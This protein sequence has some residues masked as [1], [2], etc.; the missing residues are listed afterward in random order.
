MPFQIAFSFTFCPLLLLAHTNQRYYWFKRTQPFWIQPNVAVGNATTT[1]PAATASITSSD[2]V[3]AEPT[4]TS[5]DALPSP[6]AD[7]EVELRRPDDNDAAKTV[8]GGGIVGHGGEFTFD[9]IPFPTMV[10]QHYHETLSYLRITGSQAKTLAQAQSLVN[11][12]EARYISRV[13]INNNEDMIGLV[14][15]GE[16]QQ[17][18]STRNGGRMDAIAEEPEEAGEGMFVCVYV[19]AAFFSVVGSAFSPE[20]RSAFALFDLLLI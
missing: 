14:S 17:P 18:V 5:E 1:T 15:T 20:R 9:P 2:S 6:S 10:E 3:S 16:E 8:G 12:L 11:R 4:A 7:R 19:R 13:S